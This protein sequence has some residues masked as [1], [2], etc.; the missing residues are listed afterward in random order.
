MTPGWLGNIL[1]DRG[2]FTA[3]GRVTY[4]GGRRNSIVNEY[5]TGGGGGFGCAGTTSQLN[6]VL[7][8]GTAKRPVLTADG[9]VSIFVTK[10]LTF[11]E[12]NSYSDVR[13]VGDD[14]YAQYSGATRQMSTVDFQYLG[15]RLFSASLDAQYRFTPKFE[16]YT[17]Y[18]Y[19]GRCARFKA[20]PRH[21]V[22]QVKAL[23]PQARFPRERRRQPVEE[24]RPVN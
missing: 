22:S 20:Q 1:T 6:E 14:T 16:A 4:S 11:V 13:I 9:S 17:G 8:F 18:Q 15:I 19:S 23:L 5:Y 3:N 21:R 7:V 10:K 12:N 2:W 24:A